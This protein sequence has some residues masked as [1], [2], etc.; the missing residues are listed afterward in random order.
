MP[1]IDNTSSKLR[2]R[3]VYVG[4]ASISQ[5]VSNFYVVFLIAF[6]HLQNVQHSNTTGIPSKV[7]LF[8]RRKIRLIE[9]NVKCRYLKKDMYR[10]T[11]R[12]VFLCRIGLV[13]PLQ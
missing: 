6:L 9:S 3:D 2:K 12:Q 7:Q 8:D 11:L 13:V 10:G 4:L 1:G 5:A